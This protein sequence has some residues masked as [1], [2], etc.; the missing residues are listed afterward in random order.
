[1]NPIFSQ[2]ILKVKNN[3]IQFLEDFIAVETRIKIT[4]NHKKVIFLY[5]TPIQIKELV[6]GFL[7]NE[8]IIKVNPEKIEI[9]EKNG[10]IEVN[11]K[12]NQ[13]LNEDMYK[14]SEEYENNFRVKLNSLF[15]LFKKFQ[16]KSELYKLTGCIH[17]AGLA[18]LERIIFLGEDIGRYNA[19]DKVVGFAFLNKI[20]LRNKILLLSGRISSKMVLK[21]KRVKIPIIV[22][23]GAPTSLAIEVAEK[24]DITIVGFLRT[25]RCN[26]YTCPERITF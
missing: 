20:S 25:N 16:K 3:Y 11:V 14:L 12:E 10:E 1:M 24:A 15:S 21:A 23:R 2:K 13:D 6:V 17:Y 5:A 26:I 18:N 8:D 7:F 22:S 9:I 4:I 19:V